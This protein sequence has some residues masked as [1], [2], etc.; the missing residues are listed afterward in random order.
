MAG[1]TAEYNPHLPPSLLRTGLMQNSLNQNL[2]NLRMAG[3]T[4]EYNLSQPF[5]PA[6]RAPKRWL[7]QNSR[8]QNLQNFE[9]GRNN[10][11]IQ[12][13]PNPS[14]LRTGLQRDG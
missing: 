8:N 1:I 4:A 5:A 7:M 3:I 13:S 6:D 9:N 14:L 11:R 12:S 2:Q 10:S